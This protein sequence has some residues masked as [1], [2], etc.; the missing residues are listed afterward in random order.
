MLVPFFGVGELQR[1]LGEGK[2]QQLFFS[3]NRLVELR[4]EEALSA[5][6]P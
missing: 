5:G 1:V 4:K 2:L 6:Q 3:R